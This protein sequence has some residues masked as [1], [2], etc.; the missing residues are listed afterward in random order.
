MPINLEGFET[1]APIRTFG[2]NF[3]K[4]LILIFFIFSKISKFNVSGFKS[5]IIEDK[6]LKLF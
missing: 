2:S 5:S 3:G 6:S 4:S 1:Q